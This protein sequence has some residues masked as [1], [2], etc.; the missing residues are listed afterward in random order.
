MAHGLIRHEGESA[1]LSE[2]DLSALP[3]PGSELEVQLRHLQLL[4]DKD[5]DRVAE[6]IK[7]WVSGDE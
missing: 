4:V 3:E 5:T 6:V 7:A 1:A 2:L